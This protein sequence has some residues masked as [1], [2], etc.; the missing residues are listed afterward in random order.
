[1][2][3]PSDTKARNRYFAM[4]LVRIIGVILTL[5][6]ILAHSGRWALP[7][8][9]AYVMIVAGVAMVFFVP[10]LMARRW[11]SRRNP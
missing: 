10:T 11:S 5:A 1:M 4:S 8:E 3:E 7:I 9:V 6:G 2:A